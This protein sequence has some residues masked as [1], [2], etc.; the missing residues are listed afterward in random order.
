MIS[1]LLIYIC[2]LFC[3]MPVI[4]H[5]ANISDFD[6]VCGYFEALEQLPDLESMTQRER[7]EF[8]VEKTRKQLP[9]SS[10]ARAAWDAIS[11]A[12]PQQRY[13]LFKSAAESVLNKTWDCPAMKKLAPRS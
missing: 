7:N 1:R 2:L 3:N 11:S 5:Q 12:E 8:I 10:N 9:N 6:Q 13:E 4:A